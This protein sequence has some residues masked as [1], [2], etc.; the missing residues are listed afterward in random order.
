[1]NPGYFP[2]EAAASLTSKNPHPMIQYVQIVPIY[3]RGM[4]GSSLDLREGIRAYKD[5]DLTET[6]LNK[7]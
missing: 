3:P 2:G 1:M 7:A 5:S 6:S 4:Q